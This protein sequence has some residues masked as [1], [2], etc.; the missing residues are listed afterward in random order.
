MTKYRAIFVLVGTHKP[1]N[2]KLTDPS[3]SPLREMKLSSSYLLLKFIH[4]PS[5]LHQSVPPKKNTGSTPDIAFLVT[6]LA[7]EF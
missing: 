3:P 4:L 1:E 2:A 6:K 7:R 5:Q